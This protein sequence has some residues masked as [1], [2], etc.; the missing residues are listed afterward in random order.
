MRLDLRAVVLATAFTLGLVPGTALAK[1]TF[2]GTFGDV[3]FKAKKYAVSCSYVGSL[4]FLNLA[5][6]TSK[7]H[8]RYQA[9]VGASGYGPSPTAPGAVFPIVLTG[10]VA[11]FFSGEGPNPPLWGGNS[12]L[13]D[14]VV[15]TITGVKRGKVIGTLD[16][17][18]REGASPTGAP[19]HG[20]A[21]FAAKCS[22]L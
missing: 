3:K 18:L 21:A 8:G 17:T 20:S 4:Q 10:A 19:I 7:R 12:G 22:S 11:T 16:A 9:G 1:G 13:G 5:G 6:L 15:I 14:P 2:K